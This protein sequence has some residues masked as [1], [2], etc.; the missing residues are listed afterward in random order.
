MA[1]GGEGHAGLVVDDVGE[2][3]AEGLVGA[4]EHILCLLGIAGLGAVDAL[5]IGGLEELQLVVG[6]HQLVALLALGLE[7]EELGHIGHGLFKG[8]L[9]LLVGGDI[10]AVELG[11]GDL[12][13][14]QEVEVGVVVG[15]GKADGEAAGLMVAGHQDQ[16]LLGMLSGKVDGHLHRVGQGHGVVDGRGGV[17]GVAGPVDLAALAHE[18]EAVVVVENLDALCHMVGEGPHLVGTVELIGHGVAIG[19]VLVNDDDGAVGHRFGVGLGFHHGVARGFCQGVEI[20]LVT[21]G[22]GGLEEGA[23]GEVVEA[24][25]DELQADLIVVVAAGLVGIEGGGRGVVEVHRGD[26]ADFPALLGFELLGNGLIGGGAGLIHVDGAGISLVAGGDGSGR[27]R[28]VGAEAVGVIGHGGAGHG[29]VHKVEVLRAIENGALVIVQAGFSL[30]VIG[31]AQGAQVVAGRLDLGI[32]HAV[33]DEQE[34][35]LG[36]GGRLLLFHGGGRRLFRL[37][38]GICGFLL[39]GVGGGRFFLLGGCRLIGAAGQQRGAE[40]Q[41]EKHG[42]QFLHG[43]RFLQFLS[44][45]MDVWNGF[46][47]IHEA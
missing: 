4:V 45:D 42:D 23:A 29:E 47:S 32:A 12:L 15:A 22:A 21:L 18:E 46:Y 24:G 7:A 35:I 11:I 27:G 39:G 8:R 36:R 10:V 31:I 14:L 19:Q 40:H 34:D 6:E 20:L 13:A 1:V 30:P 17:I 16:G 44:D 38:G 26:H 3:H 41:G 28:R 25:V 37:R 43:S 2:G 33:A 5:F 9:V